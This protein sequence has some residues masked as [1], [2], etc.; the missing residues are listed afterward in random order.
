MKIATIGMDKSMQWRNPSQKWSRI[1]CVGVILE[2]VGYG[3]CQV[4][5]TGQE[6]NDRQHEKPC[7]WV[8]QQVRN[9]HVLLLA[10]RKTV[11]CMDNLVKKEGYLEL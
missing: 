5:E 9:H 8:G 6:H 11:V 4:A 7:E 2:V 3:H 10:D 1:S